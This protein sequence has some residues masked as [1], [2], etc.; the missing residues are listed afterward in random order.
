M[1]S[2]VRMST[3]S[4]DANDFGSPRLQLCRSTSDRYTRLKPF[5]AVQQQ[6]HWSVIQ[7]TNIHV[8]LKLSGLYP[9]TEATQFYSNTRV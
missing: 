5:S 7:Q 2:S 6:R 3:Q 9:Q 1:A 8:S 4:Q